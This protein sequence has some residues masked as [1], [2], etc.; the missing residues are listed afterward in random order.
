M[1]TLPE[2]KYQCPVCEQLTLDLNCSGVCN[3]CEN[4][5]YWID[6]VGGVHKDDANEFSDPT[7]MYE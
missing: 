4:D 6:P 7:K 2:N 5:G 3:K 1:N